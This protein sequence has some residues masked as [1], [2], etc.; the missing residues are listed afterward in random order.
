MRLVDVAARPNVVPRDPFLIRERR[1]HC[2]SA[3][4]P[5]QNLDIATKSLKGWPMSVGHSA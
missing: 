1:E 4:L 2:I 3:A 5:F